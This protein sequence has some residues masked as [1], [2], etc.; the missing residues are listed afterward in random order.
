MTLD[1]LKQAD[2]VLLAGT[3]IEVFPVIRIDDATISGAKP[4]ALTRRLQTIFREALEQWLAPACLIRVRLARCR[5]L[6]IRLLAAEFKPG[7]SFS[8][9]SWTPG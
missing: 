5:S 7:R 8:S 1:E 2:E 3:T 6:C 9:E 4:E